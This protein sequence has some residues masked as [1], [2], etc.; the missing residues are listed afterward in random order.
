MKSLGSVDR[1]FAESNGPLASLGCLVGAMGLL[2]NVL[3]LPLAP[4]EMRLGS[5]SPSRSTCGIP[6]GR[7]GF[8]WLTFRCLWAAIGGPL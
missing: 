6:C 1:E 3:G 4:F 7:T 5:T 2:W 8:L